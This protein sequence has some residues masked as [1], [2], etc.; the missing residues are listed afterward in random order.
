MRAAA[1]LCLRRLSKWL[2]ESAREDVDARRKNATLSGWNMDMEAE[3][4]DAR[5][6]RGT[7]CEQLVKAEHRITALKT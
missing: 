3:L 2:V 5:N 6:V 4:V 7:M 1:R